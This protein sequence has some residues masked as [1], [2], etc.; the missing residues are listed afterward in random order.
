MN[1]KGIQSLKF[2]FKKI[3]IGT[4]FL[5]AL[6]LML[7]PSVYAYET[8]QTPGEGG[9]AQTDEIELWEYKDKIAEAN[10]DNY[11]NGGIAGEDFIVIYKFTIPN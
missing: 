9:Q 3:L 10:H 8:G 11:L 7:T 2:D 4:I 5:S 1:I 6:L